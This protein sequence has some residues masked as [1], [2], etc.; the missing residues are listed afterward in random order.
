V[1]NHT[2]KITAT[3]Y[4]IQDS[5]NLGLIY[6]TAEC[7]GIKT[8]FGYKCSHPNYRVTR[9]S[10]QWIKRVHIGSIKTHIQT[11]H[12][13]GVNVICAKISN[14]ATPLPCFNF[15]YPCTIMV[16]NESLGIP[17]NISNLCDSIVEIPMH[18]K[19]PCLN[20]AIAFAVLCNESITQFYR[21]PNH[22]P[23]KLT[24]HTH[25]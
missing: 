5:N 22:T 3:L 20:V 7:F 24:I 19:T 15:S 25:N 16:G 17:N 6:R 8:V 4:K 23:N 21:Q 9:G 12:K 13:N 1:I 18:G 11:Q 2:S 10:H 14:K